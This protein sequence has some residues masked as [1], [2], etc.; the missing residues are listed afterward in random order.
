MHRLLIPPK[1]CRASRGWQAGQT[2]TR[3]VTQLCQSDKAPV[4]KTVHSSLS[5]LMYCILMLSYITTCLLLPVFQVIQTYKE[6]F[7]E[8]YSFL[9]LDFQL[10]Y[11]IFSTF[12]NGFQ[13]YSHIIENAYLFISFGDIK[14][15]C[16]ECPNLYVCVSVLLIWR[17]ALVHQYGAASS[18]HR[19]QR[20]LLSYL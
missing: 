13:F 17:C 18:K 15:K 19:S 20:W 16:P 8:S 4:S 5:L 12:Q 7:Q 1:T 14:C 6:E 10:F 9:S 3:L 2:D 11:L